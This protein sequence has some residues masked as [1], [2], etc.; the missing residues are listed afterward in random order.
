MTASFIA[1]YFLLSACLSACLS[2]DNMASGDHQSAHG[3][4]P[5]PDEVLG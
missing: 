2:N 4:L 3:V 1:H 5:C